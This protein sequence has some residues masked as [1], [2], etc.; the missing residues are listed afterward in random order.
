LDPPSILAAAVILNKIPVSSTAIRTTISVNSRYTTNTSRQTT[1]QPNVTQFSK[2]VEILIM[3]S[4]TMIAYHFS[5][6]SKVAGHGSVQ[7]ENNSEI[8]V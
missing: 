1:I 6:H 5:S 8:I 7:Q 4:T 3:A 2:T